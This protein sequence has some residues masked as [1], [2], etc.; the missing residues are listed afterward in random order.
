M[1]KIDSPCLKPENPNPLD[2]DVYSA[3]RKFKDNRPPIIDKL[4]D[5]KEPREPCKFTWPKNS[6]LK[7]E[8]LLARMS[9]LDL[10]WQ[11]SS[12]EEVRNRAFLEKTILQKFEKEGTLNMIEDI[13]LPVEDYFQIGSVNTVEKMRRKNGVESASQVVIDQAVIADCYD[14]IDQI[15]RRLI[16]LL[17]CQVIISEDSPPYTYKV[18][19]VS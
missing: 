17:G 11:K 10:I 15:C 1:S 4:V 12:F 8:L 6:Q 7:H 14:T 13:C 16:D 9:K 18:P 5:T 3:K 19:L 2:E